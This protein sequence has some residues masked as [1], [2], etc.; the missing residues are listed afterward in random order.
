MVK[1][2]KLKKSFAN[3]FNRFFVPNAFNLSDVNLLE[4]PIENELYKS[5]KNLFAEI[6]ESLLNFSNFIVYLRFNI[7]KD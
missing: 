5:A 3:R 6:I 7:L 4:L 1:M 2:A